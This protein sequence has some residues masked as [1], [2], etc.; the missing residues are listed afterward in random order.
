[1]TSSITNFVGM[2]P[3]ILFDRFYPTA[4]GMHTVVL[5]IPLSLVTYVKGSLL[6]SKKVG[7]AEFV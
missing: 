3:Y 6:T 2:G 1:M 7:K 5:P 4:F